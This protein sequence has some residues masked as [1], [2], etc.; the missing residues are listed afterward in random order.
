MKNEDKN[1]FDLMWNAM[2]SVV[3]YEHE[4]VNFGT[5]MSA[6]MGDQLRCKE[7][8]W[9][10]KSTKKS[11]ALLSGKLTAAVCT[12]TLIESQANDNP[13]DAR[14]VA[15]VWDH[16][17]ALD[18]VLYYVQ[19]NNLSTYEVIG[20]LLFRMWKVLKMGE[21]RSTLT[22]GYERK[23]D[24]WPGERNDYKINPPNKDM[25]DA[26]AHYLKLRNE[27]ESQYYWDDDGSPRLHPNKEK[28][29]GI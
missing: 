16:S 13:N 28:E 15:D 19:A 7:T 11:L 5:G 10:D 2:E 27:H 24:E 18:Y 29:N 12:H 23:G 25:M 21:V 26:F 22:Y 14:F 9:L 20:E 4:H 6:T 3:S 8:P 1:P 17:M